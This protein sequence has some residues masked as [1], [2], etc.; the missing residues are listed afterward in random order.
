M[1]TS[2]FEFYE[3][4]RYLISGTVFLYLLLPVWS[5]DIWASIGTAE[6]LAYGFITGF[7]IHPWSLYKWVPGATTL[8]KTFYKNLERITN[9]QNNYHSWDFGLLSMTHEE[10]QHFRKYFALGATK[11]D[12]A[13]VLVLYIVVRAVSVIVNPSSHRLIVEALLPVFVLAAVFVLRDDGLNDLRRAFTLF[14]V[15]IARDSSEHGKFTHYR[16]KLGLL[17][18]VDPLPG[19]RWLLHPTD[20]LWPF[21]RRVGH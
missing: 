8:R 16:D 20:R 4:L 18:S 6:R 11:L 7:V 15:T 1:P 13:V 3:T 19:R 17:N 12:L 9:C 10:R 2:G 5:P 14:L 21:R